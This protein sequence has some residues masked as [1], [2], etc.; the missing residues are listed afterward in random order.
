MRSEV[1]ILSGAMLLEI[2]CSGPALTNGILL[3]CMQTHK[4]AIIDAPP[5]SG[6]Q[7]VGRIAELGLTAEY[8]LLTH[9]H[10]D[11]TADAAFLKKKL[12]LPLYVHKLD[13]P[14]VENPG[15]DG[16][17]LM[18]EVPKAEVDHFLED[19]QKIQLGELTLEVIHTPGHTPGGVCFYLKEQNT[20]ISGDTLFQGSIGNLSF[21]TSQPEKMW[22]SLEKLAKLPK[23]TR[24]IPGHGDETTIGAEAWLP[25]AKEYFGG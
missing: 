10:W 25:N 19:G 16:L 6:E 9:S 7:I 24:V 12:E 4:A 18:I 2:Y 21:P 17:P 20:L 14:N 3:V 8:L 22:E 11:H 1:R 13:A 5:D 15:I 23:S